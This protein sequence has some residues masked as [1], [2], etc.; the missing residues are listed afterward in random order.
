MHRS[1]LLSTIALALA[2][3]AVAQGIDR[4]DVSPR[5]SSQCDAIV[6]ASD[7]CE[8]QYDDVENEDQQELD[9]ICNSNG[10]DTAIPECEACQRQYYVEDD[11]YDNISTLLS[12][13]GYSTI[14][15]TGSMGAMATTTYTTTYTETDDDGDDDDLETDTVTSVIVAST[16]ASGSAG[17]TTQGGAAA[18]ATDSAGSATDSVGSATDSAGSAASSAT[19]SAG[20]ATDAA[21]GATDAVEQQSGNFAPMITAAPVLAAAAG[22]AAVV[23]GV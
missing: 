1:A 19:D 6:S 5:C 8:R 12:R 3:R 17:S 9:C 4:D 7:S 11:D 20:S 15:A 13:C 22:V 21:A 23:L 16:P 18:S 2:S 14:S 10:L